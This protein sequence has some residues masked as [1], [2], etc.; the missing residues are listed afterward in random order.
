MS[1][2]SPAVKSFTGQRTQR[3]KSDPQMN[4]FEMG[5]DQPAAINL[6]TLPEIEEWDDSEKLAREKEALGFYITGHPLDR[7][8]DEVKR[9]TTC[10]IQDLPGLV[11]LTQLVLTLLHIMIQD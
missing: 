9:F 5:G 10:P 1:D 3:E 7:F 11:K 4:L 2:C 6:P 8:K